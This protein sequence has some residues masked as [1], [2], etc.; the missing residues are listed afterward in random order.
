MFKFIGGKRY[1]RIKNKFI[2]IKNNR[3]VKLTLRYRKLLKYY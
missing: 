1:G 2:R 3:I